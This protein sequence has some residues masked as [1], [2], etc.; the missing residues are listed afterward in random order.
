MKSAC[1]LIPFGNLIDLYV[2][3]NIAGSFLET[4]AKAINRYYAYDYN[5]KAL[6]AK[7][8]EEIYKEADSN[9]EKNEYPRSASLAQA[10]HMKYKLEKVIPELLELGEENIIEKLGEV[11]HKR[12]NNYM[13]SIGW[14]SCTTAFANKWIKELKSHKNHAARLHT[15]ICDWKELKQVD[16]WVNA[17]NG[18]NDS[19]Q[20]GRAHV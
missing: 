7:T 1:Q 5:M 17:L 15:C 4:T 9:F 3:N 13:R 11:E 16:A 12:W 6:N 18:T 14:K 19:D 2:W 8:I 20:I 10:L